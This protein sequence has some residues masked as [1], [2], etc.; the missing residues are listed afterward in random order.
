[1]EIIQPGTHAI[2]VIGEISGIIKGCELRKD[3][4]RYE[5]A[6]FHNG[7]YKIEWMHEFELKILTENK[8]T[9]GF[10]P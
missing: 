5:F 6:Y 1:M 8:L 4:I 3:S 10:K 2:T 9:I 7:E